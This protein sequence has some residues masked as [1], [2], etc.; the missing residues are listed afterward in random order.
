MN[1]TFLLRTHGPLPGQPTTL[2]LT[3]TPVMQGRLVKIVRAIRDGRLGDVNDLEAVEL[4]DEGAVRSVSFHEARLLSGADVSQRADRSAV[5]LPAEAAAGTVTTDEMTFTL[6]H[7]DG[8]CLWV[9]AFQGD[10]AA[11]VRA[12][13]VWLSALGLPGL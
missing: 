1:K 12:V 4:Y 3:L 7:V 6:L 5:A 8:Q 10:C 13:T 9:I 11:P 2:L